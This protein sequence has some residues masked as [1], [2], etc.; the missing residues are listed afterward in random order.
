MSWITWITI[1][2]KLL[3]K[4]THD[5]DLITVSFF[6]NNQMAIVFNVLLQ[7]HVYNLGGIS[8]MC[9]STFSILLLSI[10]DQ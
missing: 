9:H 1:I 3:L 5:Y 6:R 8:I 10:Q 2:L 7:K 4:L